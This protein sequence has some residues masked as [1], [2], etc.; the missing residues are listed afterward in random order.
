MST[1]EE[2]SGWNL[3]E[4][5]PGVF[6]ELLRSLGVPMI[7][8]DLY[9]LDP[10]TLAAHEP[11]HALIFLFKWT[12]DSPDPTSGGSYDS[13][14]PG[15]FAHQVVNNACA[16]LAV[17]NALGNIPSL[18]SGQPLAELFNFTQ[19]MDPQTRGLVVTSADW[20][21]EC[22]NS[23]TPPSAISL[24]GLGLPKS[25]EDAYHFI[26]YLPFMGS[27]YELDGLKASPIRHGAYEENSEGWAGKAREVIESRIAT[28]PP[29]SL[30]FS[31]LALHDD[32]LPTLQEQLSVAQTAGDQSLLAE[33]MQNIS[34]ENSK[35]ERW[36]FENA[37]RRH[38]HMGLMHALL[39]LLAKTDNLDAAK[40]GAKT[41]MTERREK[42]K[43]RGEA[44]DED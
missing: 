40:E 36:A 33:L 12:S 44:M 19:G 15:F 28:Y 34:D 22:H 2:N 21:R 23:L 37:L 41:K 3:T 25:S 32:P 38:N 9:S 35:R 8:D 27:V 18:K 6:T 30:E 24:D 1:G 20:L 7:F 26:V 4:S 14:F 39:K 31:L 42:A 16:T 29:G 43:A 17:L 11:L 10:S 13:D 5:D